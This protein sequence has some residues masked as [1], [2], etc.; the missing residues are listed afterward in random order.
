MKKLVGLSIVFFVASASQLFAQSLGD[1]GLK[2]L[3]TSS[4]SSVG[5]RNLEVTSVS[6]DNIRNKDTGTSWNYTYSA[7]DHKGN[8]YD[9]S[10]IAEPIEEGINVFVD[11][12]I[13]KG[14]LDGSIP[15]QYRIP[16]YGDRLDA[17]LCDFSGFVLNGPYGNLYDSTP[18]RQSNND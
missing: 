9:G 3:I 14:Y 2:N 11:F 12:A 4:L 18:G 6:E 1:N 5:Y 10:I 8:T 7:K 17:G 13:A 16:P 15:P